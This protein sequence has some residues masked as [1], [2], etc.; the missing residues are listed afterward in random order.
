MMN[1]KQQVKFDTYVNMGYRVMWFHKNGTVVMRPSTF[2]ASEVVKIDIDG[3]VKNY[4]NA[5]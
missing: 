4:T 3:N 1:Q 5:W 2:V